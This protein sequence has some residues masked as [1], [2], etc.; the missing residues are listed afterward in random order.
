MSRKI[1]K[2]GKILTI[3]VLCL[4]FLAM[5]MGGVYADVCNCSSC[6]ECN[7][8]LN[9]TSCS[10]VNLN[11]SIIN[12]TGSCINNP[13][14]FNNKI[15]D[16]QGNA[17]NGNGVDEW[18]TDAG[19]YLSDKQNNTI[20]NCIITGFYHGIYIINNSNFNQISN[21]EISNNAV[22]IFS[23]A[24][25]STINSNYVCENTQSDFNSSEWLSSSGDNNTCDKAGIWNDTNKKGCAHTCYETECKFG[26]YL[27]RTI[28]EEVDSEISDIQVYDIDKDGTGEIITTAVRYDWYSCGN[29]TMKIF[30]NNYGNLV[31]IWNTTMDGNIVFTFSD[32]DN[33]NKSEIIVRSDCSNY[34]NRDNNRYK[35]YIFD[36]STLNFTK[37]TEIDLKIY[38]PDLLFTGINFSKANISHN[39]NITIT[40]KIL[41]NGSTNAVNARVELNVMNNLKNLYAVTYLNI[42]AYAE[43]TTEF[44]WTATF[45]KNEISGEIDGG[46]AIAETSESN[47][48]IYANLTVIDSNPPHIVLISPANNSIINGNLLEFGI[49]DDVGVDSVR[50]TINNGGFNNLPYPYYISTVNLSSGK[51]GVFVWANDT[52]GNSANA[53]FTFTVDS[54]PPG[55][56]FSM[57]GHIYINESA[58]IEIFADVDD[59]S[60]VKDVYAEIYFGAQ[61]SQ[62]SLNYDERS[63]KWKGNFEGKAGYYAIKIIATDALG[64]IND[65][66]IEEFDVSKIL[67]S[68]VEN[69]LVIASIIE[70]SE[71]KNS[72][73]IASVVKDS[74]LNYT[75]I[76]LSEIETVSSE[77]SKFESSILFRCNA[78]N[79]TIIRT[80]L[81]SSR[82]LGNVLLVEPTFVNATIIDGVLL[83]GSIIDNGAIQPANAG[84]KIGAKAGAKVGSKVGAKIGASIG[85]K[86]GAK[87]GACIGAKIGAKIGP[88]TGLIIADTDKDNKK[89]MITVMNQ[90]YVFE[91]DGNNNF[92]KIWNSNTIGES[93]SEILINDTDNDGNPEIIASAYNKIYI[94][95]NTGDNTYAEISAYSGIGR[96]SN[97][98]VDDLNND[99]KKEILFRNSEGIHILENNGSKI[100]EI[101]NYTSYTDN[102]WIDDLNNDGKKEIIYYKTSWIND[103]CRYDYHYSCGHNCRYYETTI[104]ILGNDGSN[105]YNEVSNTSM[106]GYVWINGMFF[107][108]LNNDGIKEIL[109]AGDKF[110]ILESRGNNFYAKTYDSGNELGNIQKILFED[111]DNDSKKEIVVLSRDY[112]YA[113]YSYQIKSKISVY[114]INECG[115]IFVSKTTEKPKYLWGE[116]FN[117]TIMVKAKNFTNITI[118]DNISQC[119]EFTGSNLAG[120]LQNGTVVWNINSC[121]ICKLNLKVKVKEGCGGNVINDVF[122]EGNKEGFNYN[123]SASA[124]IYIQPPSVTSWQSPSWQWHR[125]S[126]NNGLS[127][128]TITI[129]VQGKLRNVTVIDTLPDG[130]RLLN[131]SLT[132]TYEISDNTTRLLWNLGDMENEI[133]TINLTMDFP[134]ISNVWLNNYVYVKGQ[135]LNGIAEHSGYARIRIGD[136]ID[137]VWVFVEPVNDTK[138][139][140]DTVKFKIT[141]I[142]EANTTTRNVVTFFTMPAE[143]K[144][145]TA[146][147]NFTIIK[148]D[149]TT[150]KWHVDGPFESGVNTTFTYE[151]IGKILGN[152]SPGILTA[153]VEAYSDVVDKIEED[154]TNSTIIIPFCNGNCSNNEFCNK[155]MNQCVSKKNNNSTCNTNEE[156]MSNNCFNGICRHGLPDLVAEIDYYPKNASVGDT[157]TVITTIKNVGEVNV[158]NLFIR[159]IKPTVMN[160]PYP[161]TNISA[162]SE[163]NWTFNWTLRYGKDKIRLIVD[164]YSQINE[165]NETNNEA[166]LIFDFPIFIKTD[167]KTYKT[168]ETINISIIGNYGWGSIN[169]Y[170]NTYPFKI[171]KFENNTWKEIIYDHMYFYGAGFPPSC[172]NGTIKILP[173]CVEPVWPRCESVSI[174]YSSIWDQGNWIYANL[175]CGNTFYNK[176]IYVP[177]SSGIYKIEVYYS[178]YN[179]FGCSDEYVESDNFTILQNCSSDSDCKYGE[180]CINEICRHSLPDIVAEIDYYPKNASIGDNVTVVQ[181]IKNLGNINLTDVRIIYTDSYFA[182]IQPHAGFNISANSEINFTFNFTVKCGVNY[183]KFKIITKADTNNAINEINESNNNAML[184]FDFPISPLDL[185]AEINYSPSNASPG[186]NVAIVQKI[187]N[188]GECNLTNVRIAFRDSYSSKLA[189]FNLSANSEINFT[190]NFT[191]RYGKFTVETIVDFDNKVDETN[192]T[193]NNATLI[194]DFLVSVRTDKTIYV[195]GET[196]NISIIGNWSDSI[197]VIYP[198]TS[199]LDIKFHIFKFENESWNEIIVSHPFQ[200]PKYCKNGTLYSALGDPIFRD[201]H[202]IT[203]NSSRGWD[204]TQPNRVNLTCGNKTYNRWERLLVNPGIYKA[205]LHYTGYYYYSPYYSSHQYSGDRFYAESNNFTILQNCSS[206]SN[207][208]YGEKCI[209]ETCLPVQNYCENTSQCADNQICVNNT[210]SNLFCEYWQIARNHGCIKNNDVVYGGSS[211]GN[212]GDV[213]QYVTQIQPTTANKT[214]ESVNKSAE[215]QNETKTEKQNITEGKI[216]KIIPENKSV[217]AG[218]KFNV[219]IV[220]NEGNAVENVTVNYNGIIKFTNFEGKVEFVA[221]NESVELKASKDGYKETGESKVTITPVLKAENGNGG[222]DNGKISEE[223]KQTNPDDKLPLVMLVAIITSIVTILLLLKMFKKK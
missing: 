69:S 206:D 135:Y 82:M 92:I 148:T 77:N 108:D 175:T 37:I 98:I 147:G 44:N 213:T 150:L 171:F 5:I 205:V 182:Y 155:T 117:Y 186:D 36:D 210:C 61:I 146:T 174:N 196:V 24:A 192:E 143:F 53:T 85:A 197:G 48:K 46:N 74:F 176:W 194:F 109:I 218:E 180:K 13:V 166:T 178:S 14:N 201:C 133:K 21:N 6:G 10:V 76:N 195:L 60:A 119:F 100:S 204:Q 111:I 106:Q 20:K 96:I 141:T 184:I 120:E 160:P 78:I 28:S 42:S 75:N 63:G 87:I 125:P 12:Q 22:G 209:N 112:I 191:V 177:V 56:E 52:S 181:T 11:A 151:V 62:I 214:N 114:E 103:V 110:Y 123:N 159:D 129:K 137:P 55:V 207:C 104:G 124:S 145:I 154:H 97:L 7:E 134:N 139:P 101:A 89:E 202:I 30:K 95:E 136:Y 140:N 173:C 130:S 157:I 212:S 31:E 187:K 211:G 34:Y 19:I 162:N 38:A 188:L 163:K 127:S 131:V 142:L 208:A 193:N 4:I 107:D 27:S 121:E 105:H 158:T 45:G 23:N 185:V 179:N 156:C 118:K 70:N 35:I 90:V 167:K 190:L 81:K 84:A 88:G 80:D 49:T 91:N 161:P 113:N 219:K 200:S 172:E 66:E 25:D 170:Y 102:L 54:T 168:G 198:S 18:G 215:K 65:S 51:Y 16:C 43:A 71:L 64:N 67:N 144:L 216:L 152:T 3:S 41:N 122:A 57:P 58:N 33:D 169:V 83:N 221:F 164:E 99:G 217:I 9:E 40:L 183:S 50:Y 199:P 115:G 17:I 93:I 149:K 189:Y 1:Y 47:N 203:V 220:D 165:T 79:S 153:N 8:K 222:K 126:D 132:P 15:F 32:I 2:F 86:I 72:E 116:E 29:S 59:D 26:F 68:T 128:L 223:T 138:L 73:I 39:D 94:F